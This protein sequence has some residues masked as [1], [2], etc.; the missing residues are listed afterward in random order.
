MAINGNVV[1]VGIVSTVNP[2]EGTVKVLLPAK[3]NKITGDLSVV[4]RGTQAH[5][6]YWIPAIGE[7]VLC[8]FDMDGINHGWVLGAVWSIVDAPVVSDA[9]IRQIRFS[10][11]T[12]ISYDNSK[13]TL[14]IQCVGTININGNTIID[15][16]VFL[17]HTHDGVESGSGNT[18][19]VT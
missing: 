7:Q 6:D 10:D 3:D 19:G 12:K 5:K 11:G 4:T 2:K 15:G 9:N 14:D 13:H 18:G 1:A 16:K 17:D 8:L